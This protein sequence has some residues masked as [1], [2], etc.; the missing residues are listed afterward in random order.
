MALLL[1]AAS[2]LLAGSVLGIWLA[3]PAQ[4]GLSE[5]V[6]VFYN[7]ACGECS[8]YVQQVLLPTLAEAGYQD[9]QP[10]DYINEVEHRKK[11]N[12]L[13]D[14]F[15]IPY[16]LRS[17]LATFV[18]DGGALVF[19]GHIPEGILREGLRLHEKD[20]P[21]LLL[22]YQD[23]MNT[24]IAYTVWS[25]PREARELAIS[26]SLATYFTAEPG[27]PVGGQEWW[28]FPSFVLAAGLLDGVNP[29]AIAVL[30]F[31]VSLLYAVRRP[32]GE[33]LQ[34]GILYIFAIYLVYF[35]IGLG[36][37][38]AIVLSGEAHLLARVGAYLVIG[39][40][41][42]TIGG[43]FVKPLG[44]VTRTPH[45]FWQRAKPFLMRATLPS[46]FV[47][48]LLVGLCTFPCSGGVYVAILGLLSTSTSYVEGLGYLYLY[49][50]MFVVP[51]I[52]ILLGVQSR[53]VSTRVAAWEV[54]H[55]RWARLIG[56]SL[57]I[58]VGFAIL[59]FWI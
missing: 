34:M 50:L 33:V 51:L 19:Q 31:F 46:A 43:L 9:V 22:V 13:N 38:Q 41:V 2:I 3:K 57:M 11:L 6:Y 4:G 39:L 25:P 20:A 47:G 37:L 59:I 55:R 45:L 56:A 40:G 8:V 1:G 48:G 27:G 58:A 15:D 36:L 14:A 52:A 26:T 54:E 35:L 12:G 10:K 5:G 30:L 24:P 17:H 44:V 7:E 42:L 29:C 53:K 28:A 23:S 21:G 16:N 32:R 49:N 18:V